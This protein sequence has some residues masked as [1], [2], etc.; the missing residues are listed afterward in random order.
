MVGNADSDDEAAGQDRTVEGYTQ[1]TRKSVLAAIA[2]T[3]CFVSR[4]AATRSAL[5]RKRFTKAT[6]LRELG[7]TCS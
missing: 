5:L 4:T 6:Q 3:E 2:L 7:D 1:A